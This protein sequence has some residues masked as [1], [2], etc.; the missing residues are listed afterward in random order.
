MSGRTSLKLGDPSILHFSGLGIYLFLISYDVLFFPSGSMVEA[1]QGYIAWEI[2][3]GNINEARSLYKRC[4]SKRFPGTGSEV[5][6]C[7]ELFF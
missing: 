7:A 1:W 5:R 2:E 6:L 3:T 4:Y